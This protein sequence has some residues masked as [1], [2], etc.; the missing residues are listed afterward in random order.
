MNKF[1]KPGKKNVFQICN[2]FSKV[3]KPALYTKELK[4]NEKWPHSS[5]YEPY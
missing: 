3:A 1:N 5:T 4:G 2:Y